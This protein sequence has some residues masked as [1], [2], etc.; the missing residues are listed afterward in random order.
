MKRGIRQPDGFLTYLVGW[1][2]ALII[3]AGSTFYHR[4]YRAFVNR[5]AALYGLRDGT[6]S[7]ALECELEGALS[8]FLQ[9]RAFE[10]KW[11][12]VPFL[13]AGGGGYTECHRAPDKATYLDA[14]SMCV[15]IMREHER[16]ANARTDGR[17]NSRR[18]VVP[19]DVNLT[20]V[21][22]H[23]HTAIRGGLR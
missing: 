14:L 3:K 10:D 20:A 18:P 7:V 6:G 21:D 8:T 15:S 4:R 16:T 13:G 17:T 1:D 9:E 22:A 23:A 12:A 5:G 19:A 2:E 11:V